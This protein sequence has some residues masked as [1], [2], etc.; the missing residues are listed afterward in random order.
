MTRA[1]IER[2]AAM[3]TRVELH[4]F[5]GATPAALADARRAVEAVD[6]ALTIHRPSPLV[7]LNEALL[8]GREAAV[9]DAIL[10]DA[11]DAAAAAHVATFGLFDVAADRRTG[12]NWTMVRFDRAGGTVA[13]SRPLALDFGGL[14]KGLALDRAGAV[15]RD[16]GVTSALLSAG[17]SSILA[18]GPHPLGG[19]WPFA[20]P[21]PIDADATLLEIELRDQS[22]SISATVGVGTDAPERAALLRPGEP[23]AIA[24]PACAVAIAES[25]AAAEALSTALVVADPARAARLLRDR[26]DTRFRFDLAHQESRVA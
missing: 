3:G 24:P 16:A 12:G 13:A 21:H 23:A 15:L 20:I 5:D 26:R 4:A 19:G 18:F 11:L 8:A 6:D 10:L 9:T 25:G 2:F 22:L 1:R 14:G 17:E 7:A